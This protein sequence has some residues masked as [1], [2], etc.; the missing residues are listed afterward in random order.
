MLDLRARKTLRREARVAAA[1]VDDPQ[2][3]AE[4][5]RPAPSAATSSAWCM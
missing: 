1:E 2:R 3:P 5:F 4:L